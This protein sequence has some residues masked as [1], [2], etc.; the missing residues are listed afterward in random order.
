MTV[1]RSVKASV[2]VGVAG[3]AGLEEIQ[4]GVGFI[5]RDLTRI[6]EQV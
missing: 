6:R 5:E 2:E 1:M 3:H 4:A